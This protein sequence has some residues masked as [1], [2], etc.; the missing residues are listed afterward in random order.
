MLANCFCYRTYVVAWANH[1]LGDD[2]ENKY[3]FTM[4]LSGC[5]Q[6]HG[7]IFDF[8]FLSIYIFPSFSKFIQQA[9]LERICSNHQAF[10]N[11]MTNNE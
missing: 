2:D 11:C 1:K 10:I 7:S 5:F 3:S 8:L 9:L 6:G 4:N